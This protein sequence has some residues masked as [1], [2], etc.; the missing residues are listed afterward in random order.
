MSA[1]GGS[2][3]WGA[4]AYSRSRSRGGRSPRRTYQT[5]G[6][7]RWYADT[8]RYSL[9]LAT[10]Q[11][12]RVR[13]VSPASDES[14]EIRRLRLVVGLDT[15]IAEGSHVAVKFGLLKTSA[16][17]APTDAQLLAEAFPRWF[18]TQLVV[19]TFRT[20]PIVERMLPGRLQV[21]QDQDLSICAYVAHA[22]FNTTVTWDFLLDYRYRV[23]ERPDKLT[24]RRDAL[25]PQGLLPSYEPEYE[26][27]DLGSEGYY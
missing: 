22:D 12:K 14:I 2:R 5:K 20:Q 7:H 1:Y 6:V 8:T 17:E 26:E 19:Y 27:G 24:G 18:M 15:N 9:A 4:R 11:A 10:G 16:I 13:V 3:R 23:T 25:Q 21:S